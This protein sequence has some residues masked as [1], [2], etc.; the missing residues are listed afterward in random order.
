MN[1]TLRVGNE[2]YKKIHKQVVE[3]ITLII[4]AM[5]ELH[6]YYRHHTKK[7]LVLGKTK[8]QK[9]E[10]KIKYK[11]NQVKLERYQNFIRAYNKN[12]NI[13]KERRMMQRMS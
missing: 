12:L 2:E 7:G 8:N 11:T 13:I 6:I 10:D 4:N 3:Y 1:S 5:K 9:E